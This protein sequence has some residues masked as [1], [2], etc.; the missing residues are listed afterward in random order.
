MTSYAMIGIIIAGIVSSIAFGTYMYAEYQPNFITVQAGQ[1]VQVG[2]VVYTIEHIGEHKGDEDIKPENIFFQIK[3]S[4]EN[5]GSETTFLSGGQF[6][7]LDETDKKY[8]AVYGKF[9]EEDLY[10]D[11]LKPNVPIT[12]TTQFDILYDE[13]MRYRIGILPTKEQSSNDI[14][15]ICVQ[16]C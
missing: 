11:N 5:V 10:N 9:S 7:L 13:K 4:A 16:N 1:P 6:Y 15:I 8:S 12:R 14:G 2:P 3:I